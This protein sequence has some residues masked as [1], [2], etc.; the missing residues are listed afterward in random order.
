MLYE[1]ITQQI[2]GN[3]VYG[4]LNAL[5]TLRLGV[6]MQHELFQKRDR[7]GISI[8]YYYHGGAS[9]GVQK[10]VYYLIDTVG[11]ATNYVRTR[12]I[13][14]EDKQIKLHQVDRKLPFY[15][16]LGE[17]RVVPGVYTKVGFSF[18]F[19]KNDAVFNALETGLILDVFYRKVPIMANELNH[20]LYPAFYVSYRFG[21]V[22]DTQFKTRLNK[23][24][25]VLM[26][27]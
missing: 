14:E 5:G 11:D 8:R 27:Q 25:R 3:F 6:G 17:S 10:P 15:E 9:I 23:V 18:E 19:S 20:W 1:V 26:E 21:R 16:G 7:G 2:G 4:K 24:D 22:V 12:W 13:E